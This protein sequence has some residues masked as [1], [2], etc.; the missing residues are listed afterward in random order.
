MDQKEMKELVGRTAVEKLVR[1][2]MKLGLGTGSTAMPAVRRIG[3]LLRDGLLHDIKAVPTSFQT[4]I[5]CEKWGIPLYSLNSKEID[6]SLDLTIDGADE[7]DGQGYCVKGGGGALL[8]EKIVAYASKRY[9]IVADET[10]VVDSL[11][12]AFPVPI[13]TIPEARI[14]VSRSLEALGATVQLREALRKAGPVITEHANLL[15]DIRF[16]EKVDALKLESLLSQI[17]GVVGNGFFTRK[18]PIVFIGHLAGT[19][20]IREEQ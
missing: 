17:P 8:V 4:V 15:L 1:S 19:V 2:G 13:E 7:V 10:K 12:L 18:P 9:A 5:E 20:E 11:G 14:T 16:K 3:E 6:G